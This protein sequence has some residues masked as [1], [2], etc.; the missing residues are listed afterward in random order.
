MQSRNFGSIE[1]VITSYAFVG[2]VYKST[3]K[4]SNFDLLTQLDCYQRIYAL[5]EFLERGIS[6]LNQDETIKAAL[7]YLKS[8][9]RMPK[10]FVL[11]AIEVPMDIRVQLPSMAAPK[12]RTRETMYGHELQSS[13]EPANIL[14]TKK[15]QVFREEIFIGS[16]EWFEDCGIESGIEIVVYPCTK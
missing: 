16:R 8:L 1:E 10:N 12:V 3:E 2:P 13:L 14:R 5:R 7:N 9:Q 15:L 6:A 4:R 11:K